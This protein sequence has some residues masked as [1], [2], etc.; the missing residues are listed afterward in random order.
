M[1]ERCQTRKDQIDMSMKPNALDFKIDKLTF[2]EG[3]NDPA[4]KYGLPKHIEF[5]TK[6][7]ISNQRP[8]SAVEF[9]HNAETQKKTIRFQDG[10]CDAC[11]M[12]ERKLRGIDWE[13]REREL[14]TLCDRFRS[15]RVPRHDHVENHRRCRAVR[16]RF[17]AAIDEPGRS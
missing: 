8:S 17:A 16:P 13:E 4:R 6:C 14:I 3:A 7:C 15:R 12:A 5:C 1:A 11:Q 2:A 10:I 9:E